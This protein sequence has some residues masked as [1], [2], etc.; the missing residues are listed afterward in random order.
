MADGTIVGAA[1]AAALDHRPDAAL[2]RDIGSA[3]RELARQRRFQAALWRL[4]RAPRLM[5]ELAEP[6]TIL[7]RCE[8]VT[9]A[10]LDAA[11]ADSPA[12]IGEIK[13]RTRAG[14]GAC[15]GR[16]CGPLLKAAIAAAGGDIA[17]SFAPRPPVKPLTI[18]DLARSPAP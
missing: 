2:A 10:E 14:M 17:E 3:R 13:R 9:K 4:Y 16:Y 8:E 12:P 6:P 1:A 15:Q 18:A 7:C 11:L 5:L